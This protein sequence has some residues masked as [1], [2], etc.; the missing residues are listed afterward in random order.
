MNADL[1]LVLKDGGI[2][3][4]GSHDELM[5]NKDGVY[6]DM[7]L[8]QLKD[9]ASPTGGIDSKKKKKKE[10]EDSDSN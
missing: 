1:I 4:R 10:E 5:A 9:E 8:K 6:H 2:V 3:E 7:W